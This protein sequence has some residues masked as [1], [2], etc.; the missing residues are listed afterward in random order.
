[1][2]FCLNISIILF[3]FLNRYF[4]ILSSVSL[5]PVQISQLIHINLLAGCIILS[6]SHLQGR[7]FCI[8]CMQ[9]YLC[10]KRV[11]IGLYYVGDET[12][13]DVDILW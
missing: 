8:F 7:I 2:I 4:T 1:M 9:E 11:Q 12:S 13:F 3:I 6:H 5:F 10:V